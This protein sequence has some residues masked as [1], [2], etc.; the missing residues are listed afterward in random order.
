M[1]KLGLLSVH[2]C[3]NPEFPDVG[4]Q[5]PQWAVEAAWEDHEQPHCITC[6]R[7]SAVITVQ[8]KVV[9]PAQESE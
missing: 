9:R 3:N 7:P 6:K 8:L 5:V 2:I 4:K 1:A